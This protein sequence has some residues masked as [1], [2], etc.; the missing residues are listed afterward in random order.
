[1]LIRIS[2]TLRSPF[3]VEQA[4]MSLLGIELLPRVFCGCRLFEGYVG[5]FAADD[6]DFVHLD[7]LNDVARLGI[8]GDVSARTVR[9]FPGGKVLH[10][11]GAVRLWTEF[12]GG[13]IDRRHGVPT[14][15]RLDVRKRAVSVLGLPCLQ[16]FDVARILVG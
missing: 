6:L 13:C 8:N 12:L 16:E 1:M 3:L 7:R 14:G 15:N 5:W 4:R 9:A 11:G 2:I 10:D